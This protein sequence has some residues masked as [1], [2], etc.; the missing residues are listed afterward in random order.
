MSGAVLDGVR[1]HHSGVESDQPTAVALA[2]LIGGLVSGS[3]TPA[4]F[5]HLHDV[6]A[7][8]DPLPI[9]DALTTELIGRDLPG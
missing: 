8:Q 5:Q 6:A 9:R 3:A 7:E 2:D 4:E 1:T